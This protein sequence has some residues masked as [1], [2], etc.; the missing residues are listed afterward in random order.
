MCAAK[1][2]VTIKGA[3]HVLFIHQSD[4]YECHC[5]VECIRSGWSDKKDNV[6]SSYLSILWLYMSAIVWT[7]RTGCLSRVSIV[8]M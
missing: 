2:G 5:T 6:M 8:V 1:S 3:R 4:R 7:L